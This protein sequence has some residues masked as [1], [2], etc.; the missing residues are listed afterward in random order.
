MAHNNRAWDYHLKGADALGL[1]DA[2]TAVALAPSEADFMETRA[3]IYEKLGRRGEAV[4]DY[5]ATLKL[6]PGHRSAVEGLRRLGVAA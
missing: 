5:K 1:P 3:E 6:D 2:E 4:A